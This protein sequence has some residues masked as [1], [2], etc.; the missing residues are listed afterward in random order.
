[1]DSPDMH[2]NAI[3][4]TT[5]NSIQKI[6][7]LTGKINAWNSESVTKALSED[8]H[9]EPCNLWNGDLTSVY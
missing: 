7:H 1:M 6:I 3:L 2:F 5:S 8:E 4:N 9:E